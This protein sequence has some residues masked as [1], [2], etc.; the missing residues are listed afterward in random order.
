MLR[1][2]DK[3]IKQHES[4]LF[5]INYSDCRRLFPVLLVGEP[6]ATLIQKLIN[7]IEQSIEEQ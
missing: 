3:L 4:A 6:R 1:N 7:I 2:N 5:M